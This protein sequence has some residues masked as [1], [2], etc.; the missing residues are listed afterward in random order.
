MTN[1][2]KINDTVTEL[3][4]KAMDN[5]DNEFLSNSYLDEAEMIL[6]GTLADTPARE[7]TIGFIIPANSIDWGT[8]N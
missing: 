6:N 7:N 1:T 4:Q 5:M 8:Y 2:V 3:I